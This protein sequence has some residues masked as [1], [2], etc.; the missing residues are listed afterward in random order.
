MD[1]MRES[2]F[3][4]LGDLGGLS[5]LD[6]FA[7]SG[8]LGLEA[9][10]R[11]ADPVACVEKD[12]S[13]FPTLLQNVS[14]A[15]RR[16][17]CHAMPVERFILR[18]KFAFSVIFLD[19]PFPYEFRLELLSRLSDSPTL[20]DDGLLLIHHPREDRLPSELGRIHL[21][22]E[23]EFGRSIVKFYRSAPKS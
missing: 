15:P 18:N 21:A 2:I 1:R 6:L 19:P 22:D 7:G 17:D 4:I 11:G 23:R 16:I 20:A 14:I 9:A 10:S 3:A 13:K 5:F 8:I 12:R